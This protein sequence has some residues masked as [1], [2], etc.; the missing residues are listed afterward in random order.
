MRVLPKVRHLAALHKKVS[1]NSHSTVFTY[2]VMI[3]S[4]IRVCYPSCS[5]AFPLYQEVRRRVTEQLFFM[6]CSLELMTLKASSVTDIVTSATSQFCRG[7][8]FS[9][10]GAE[11][12]WGL[13]ARS[14]HMKN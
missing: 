8:V 13:E 2:G 5:L 4:H 7:A 9:Q 11:E 3:V 6:A 12:E 10:C 14:Y 1:S